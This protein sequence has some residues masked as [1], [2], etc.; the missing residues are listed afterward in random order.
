MA[1][2]AALGQVRAELVALTDSVQPDKPLTV[3]LR[4]DHTA[5]WHTYWINAGTGYPTSI[6]WELPEGWSAGDIQWP[7][8]LKIVDSHAEITGNGYD[9]ITYL[10]ITLTPP[11]TLEAGTEVTLKGR[12][13]W[14]M[15]EDVCVPGNEDVSLTL[16]VGNETAASP[17]KAALLD[18]IASFPKKAIDGVS[19]S[20]TR[21]GDTIEL[22]IAGLQKEPVEPWLFERNAFV[23]YNLPQSYTYAQGVLVVRLA[24]GEFYDGDGKNLVGVLTQSGSWEVDAAVPAYEID[25]ELGASPIAQTSSQA[26]VASGSLVGTLA[27]AFLGGLILNLMPCVFPVLGIKILGFVNQAGSDRRKVALH[28]WAFS[29]GVLASFWALAG[30]LA[31]LRSSGAELGWGFQLQSPAFVF[32]LAALMLVFALSMSGVFEFGLSATGVGAKLQSKDGYSGSF[33]TGVLATVVATPCSAPFLAPALGAAL[34]L[35]PFPR[36]SSLPLLRSASP[37]R[38]CCCRFFRTR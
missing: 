29:V 18:T 24:V 37:L 8:P 31:I 28:G 1:L 26:T 14:L 30:L 34:A 5:H 21:S 11:A 7:T 4:L 33:F 27:A 17:H 20:A 25:I 10:P 2:P 36:F 35:P 6:E 32:A 3:A 23:E 38:I 16:K 19:A 12:V 13:D 22:T 9:G 15:C